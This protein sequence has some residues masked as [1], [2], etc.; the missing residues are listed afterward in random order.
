MRK[1][2]NTMDIEM[3]TLITDVTHQLDQIGIE[4]MIGGSV[5]SSVHGIP[6][7]TRDLDIVVDLKQAHIPQL[8][9]VFKPNYYIDSDMIQDAIDVQ[10]SPNLHATFNIFHNTNM[11][12]VDMFLLKPDSWSQCQ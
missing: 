8:V 7:F 10:L 4:Y 9:S 2:D 12:K 5:A 6:R 1:E 11:A 3:E